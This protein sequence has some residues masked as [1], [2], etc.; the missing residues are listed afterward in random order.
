M[1][2]LT[3]LLCAALV[4]LAVPAAADDVDLELVLAMDASD[5]ISHA[6]YHL[7]LTGTASAFRDPEIQ[8]AI[9]SGPLGKIAVTV[10]LWSD[11]LFEK[12]NSGWYIID[13]AHSAETF[14]QMVSTFRLSDDKTLIMTGGGGTGI[15]AGVEE[16]LKLLS[17]NAHNGDR[18]IIDVSGDGVETE[19]DFSTNL[20]IRDARLLADAA[21]VTVNGL[22]I[23]RN[24]DSDLAEYYRMNVITGPGAFVEKADGF[25]D[26]ARAIRK[27]LLREIAVQVADSGR[28]LPVIVAQIGQ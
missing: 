17:S 6:E 22:P 23:T 3:R 14:A 9:T 27:K 5:S 8:A 21:G 2:T 15:G 24:N 28:V 12:P 26:F 11:A 16:A 19:F 1:G 18:K 10:M 4:G 20:M 25:D 13:G 7:Q